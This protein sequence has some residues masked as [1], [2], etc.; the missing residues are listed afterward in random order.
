M[1]RTLLLDGAMGTELIKKLNIPQK[2]PFSAPSINL[3]NPN[4]VKQ[5][6]LDYLEAGSDIITTNTFTANKLMQTYYRKEKELVSQNVQGVRIAKQ[7]VEEYY[8]KTGKKCYV[9]G[10]IGPLY[11]LEKNMSESVKDLVNYYETQ[12][13]TLI[14]ESPD[15]L[16]IECAYRI[17]MVQ[18]LGKLLYSAFGSTR[19]RIPIMFTVP[20]YEDPQY[21]NGIGIEE[22]FE[23]AN[24]EFAPDFVGFTC[25]EGLD[26]MEKVIA[27]LPMK[28]KVLAPNA[29]LPDQLGHY[30]KNLDQLADRLITLRNEFDLS[31]LGGCCGTTPDFIKRLYDKL[32]RDDL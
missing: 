19:E 8:Q 10:N 20:I 27:R 24:E 12:L 11:F 15:L 22:F 4:M 9:G 31:V 17:D 6:H 3:T 25:G 18:A 28:R 21:I 26:R 13:F 1:K 32:S 16:I 29:G 7:A 23:V 30:H 5:I 2:T 14:E